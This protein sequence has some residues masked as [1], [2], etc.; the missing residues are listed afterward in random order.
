MSFINSRMSKPATL[1][2]SAIGDYR[3]ETAQGLPELFVLLA[4]RPLVEPFALAPFLPEALEDGDERVGHVICGPRTLDPVY[5]GSVAPERT[6]YA[7]V[8]AL[9]YPVSL[10]GG[11][12]SK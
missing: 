7:D 6:T 1:L 8:H 10:L 12:A 4:T 2:T 11:L 9:D 3:N 5:K